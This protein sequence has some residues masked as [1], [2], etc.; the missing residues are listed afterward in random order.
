V[1]VLL[2]MGEPLTNRLLTYDALAMTFREVA[3]RRNPSCPLCGKEAD[4]H[5]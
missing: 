2:G 4:S 5:G 1:K 3:V